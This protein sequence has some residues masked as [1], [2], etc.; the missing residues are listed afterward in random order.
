MHQEL[1]QALLKAKRNISPPAKNKKAV[2]GRYADLEAVLGAVERPLADQ[3]LFISQ[4]GI[5]GNN[6]QP[7]LRTSIIHAES[8]QSINSDVPLVSKNA[9]DPQQLGSS[10]TYARRYGITAILSVVADDDDDGN[11][12]AGKE[13]DGA[14]KKKKDPEVTQEKIEEVFSVPNGLSNKL[15]D[16]LV[17]EYKRAEF[18]S[19]EMMAEIRA[20]VNRDFKQLAELTEAEARAAAGHVRKVKRGEAERLSGAS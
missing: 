14:P 18:S 16:A 12:S 15:V 7:W 11:S 9:N 17:N 10:I 4:V 1:Y 6:G 19:A 3:G 20:L 8:G 5:E 2:Y 13:R